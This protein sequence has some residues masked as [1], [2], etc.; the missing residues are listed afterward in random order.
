MTT[1]IAAAVLMAPS[2]PAFF[3]RP[4]TWGL[5]RGGYSEWP[6][7][8]EEGLRRAATLHPDLI[9]E[10]DV[11]STSDGVPILLHDDTVNRTTNG[12]GPV[13]EMTWTQVQA[14]DAGYRWSRTAG[15][16]PFR[17]KG[18]TIPTLRAALRAAPRHRFLIDLK[19]AARVDE[20]VK[21]IRDEKAEDR[22]LVASF[23][24][25]Q[26]QAFRRA[27]PQVP[28][29]YDPVQG[30]QLLAALRG[31]RWET[32]RPPVPVLSLMKE[33][34]DQ[35]RLT[36][37][38]FR[39]LAAKGIRLHVHTLETKEEVEIW[40]ARGFSGWLTGDSGLVKDQMAGQ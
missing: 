23:L 29:C 17:A 39:R 27:M 18:L 31:S 12:S 30:M 37:E 24:A 36:D 5:H 14:L 22:V 13:A 35:Y 33:H 11:T 4:M 38:E 26:I 3:A 6:E 20:V 34:R 25:G 1:W 10:T 19:P 40:R 9:L 28:T 32:Y 7:N 8:T 21:V 2:E 15:T 16:F